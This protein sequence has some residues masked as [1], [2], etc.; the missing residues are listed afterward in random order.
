ALPAEDGLTHGGAVREHGHHDS[1]AGE[2]LRRGGGLPAV[3]ADEPLLRA[4]VAV[5][6]HQREAGGGEGG[7]HPAAHVADADEPHEAPGP[8]RRAHSSPSSAS[9][10]EAWRKPSTAAGMPQ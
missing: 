6:D 4:G 2:R 7:G 5:P 3:P 8:R 1:G 10:A 9:T